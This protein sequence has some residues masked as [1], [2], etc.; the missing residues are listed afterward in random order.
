[1]TF[2]TA[3][4]TS[5]SKTS[6]DQSMNGEAQFRKTSYDQTINGKPPPPLP[7]LDVETIIKVD[8]SQSFFYIFAPS[9]KSRLKSLSVP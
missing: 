7:P 8:K 9:S 3:G 6:E 1:M 2:Y 4:N 5:Y